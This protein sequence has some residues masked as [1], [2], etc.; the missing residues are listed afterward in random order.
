ML[1]IKRSRLQVFIIAATF[2]TT[3]GVGA[4]TAIPASSAT[5]TVSGHVNCS[6]WPAGSANGLA[7]K[8]QITAGAST[9][10]GSVFL[11]NYSV[12][13]ANVPSGS[14][15]ATA[16]VS[17]GNGNT[18]NLP[19]Q[20]NGTSGT[21][22]DLTNPTPAFIGV[23]IDD[24]SS[25]QSVSYPGVPIRSRWSWPLHVQIYNAKNVLVGT[26]TVTA[27]W[28]QGS[29]EWDAPAIFLGDV[30][31]GAYYFIAWLD[32]TLHKQVAGIYNVLSRSL[33]YTLWGFF[34][35][36]S[37]KLTEGDINQDNRI[38]AADFNVLNACYSDLLPPKG[39][40]SS[41][42]A[43]GSDLNLDGKVNGTDYNLWLR[44][45]KNVSG[46]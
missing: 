7:T 18:W 20:L 9:G 38:T 42:Q 1:R 46:G 12:A 13:L 17:C 43:R 33:P 34:S 29:D 27:Q 3:C 32:F 4:L 45:E 39:P 8:V 6:G 16:T 21:T 35:S 22:L 37:T 28:V 14:V 15:S 11:G 31:S 24:P 23:H 2:I 10:S 5:V 36:T 26:R 19:F 44:I 25:G 40:C 41:T 30:P